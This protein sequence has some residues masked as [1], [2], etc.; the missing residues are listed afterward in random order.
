MKFKTFMHIG[1]HRNPFTFKL[2]I[3]VKSYCTSIQTHRKIHTVFSTS[4]IYRKNKHLY[5]LEC[6][7]ERWGSDMAL[8]NNH[9]PCM[10]IKCWYS[11]SVNECGQWRRC[12]SRIIL[13]SRVNLPGSVWHSSEGSW[14]LVNQPLRGSLHE[15]ESLITQ[16]PWTVSTLSDF[17]F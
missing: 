5:N 6:K 13:S 1:I 9:C 12:P 10:W 2:I 4:T 16:W 17:C 15:L 14:Q 7:Y 3:Q 8:S 11:C